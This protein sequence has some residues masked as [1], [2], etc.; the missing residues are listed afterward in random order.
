MASSGWVHRFIARAYFLSV[1][2][3]GWAATAADMKAAELHNIYCIEI[4]II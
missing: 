1:K 4:I 2:V 3:S